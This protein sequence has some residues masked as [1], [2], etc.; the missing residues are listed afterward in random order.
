MIV[1]RNHFWEVFRVKL[2][3]NLK[4]EVSR[5]YLGYLWWLM[6]PILYV[7]AM[8]L[9]FGIFLNMRTDN[10]MIFLVSGQVPFIW[11][12]R[13]VGN[14]AGTIVSGKGL[15]GQVAIPK[16]IFPMLSVS[17]DFVKQGIVFIAMI[18]FFVVMDLPATIYWLG[19]VPIAIV[20][21]LLITSIGMFVA[22]V[23]PYFPDFKFLVTTGLRLLMY[24]SGIFYSY[25]AVALPKHRDLF[26]LNPVANLLKN[27]RD[28]F[29]HAQWPDWQALGSIALFSTV[30]ITIMYFHF[31]RKDSAYARLILQ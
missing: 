7:L 24:G 10:F 8:Y 17:Q 14:A 13:S 6:E 28:V 3:F 5:T 12:S 25:E 29:L 26:L 27:Y 22:S 18:G 23:I 16:I 30:L 1:S 19:V 4:S 20:Q 21:F 15:I 2:K 11:F 31:K 9:V